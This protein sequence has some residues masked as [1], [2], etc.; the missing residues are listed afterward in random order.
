MKQIVRIIVGRYY[1][2]NADGVVIDHGKLEVPLS[3]I[4]EKLNHNAEISV[5]VEE[6]KNVPCNG[7]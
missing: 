5:I 1:I 7:R 6:Y 2:E 4:L 3:E